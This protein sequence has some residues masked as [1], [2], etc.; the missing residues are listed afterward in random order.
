MN[1]LDVPILDLYLDYFSRKGFITSWVFF[2]TTSLIFVAVL[3]FYRF[4]KGLV[5]DVHFFSSAVIATSYGSSDYIYALFFTGN[6]KGAALPVFTILDVITLSL[7]L[8]LVTF[9]RSDKRNRI[10][11]SVIFSVLLLVINGIAHAIYFWVLNFSDIDVAG[12]GYYISALIYSVVININDLLL[13][14]VG[15]LPKAFDVILLKIKK[16]IKSS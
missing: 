6:F 3:N 12:K 11:S 7:I 4:K 15:L 9:F 10:P 8:V 2:I 16:I 14:A 5:Q 1:F 13:I